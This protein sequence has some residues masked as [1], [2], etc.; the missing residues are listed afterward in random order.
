MVKFANN[1]ADNLFG[2][3]KKEGLGRPFL[4]FVASRF[5][6]QVSER[7]ASLIK[8]HSSENRYEFSV[9]SKDGGEIPVEANTSVI[10]YEDKPAVMAIIRDITKL[11]EIDKMKSE[12]V[13]TASHQLRTPLT[14]IKWFAELLLNDKSGK[15]TDK[16]DEYVSNIAKSNERLIKLVDDLLDV[17]RI[18][19]SKKNG[20]KLAPVPFES[21]LED[22]V[23]SLK[24]IAESKNIK[25]HL[26]KKN[27]GGIA[28]LADKEKIT[29]VFKNIIDNAIKYSSP[30]SEVIVG[31]EVKEKI[32]ICFVED[33]G[34]GIPER[35]HSKI[36]QQFFR[37]DN[38]KDKEYGTGLGLYIAKAI[39]EKHKGRIWFES[40]E[41]GGTTFY[42]SLPIKLII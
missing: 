36:F 1:S 31:C 35:D 20:I 24:P 4:D 38:V 22:A 2:Y 29:E 9:I 18:D 15:L 37:S 23:K 11:K 25:I 8:G 33:H 34:L 19:A 10:L 26:N 12:F 40:K 27:A 28:V 5:R 17:T 3:L 6:T 21:L 30:K 13:S 39:V 16:Q 32:A 14:G 7:Y 42:F 41:N